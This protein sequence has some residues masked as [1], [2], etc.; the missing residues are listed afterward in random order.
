MIPNIKPSKVYPVAGQ[1]GPI[2][3]A[4]AGNA[5]TSWVQVPAGSK[6]AIAELLNGVLGGGSEQ[7]D[8]EQAT[9]SG[10]AGAKA[11]V[12]NAVT[13]AVNNTASQVEANLDQVLDVAGGFNYV[14]AKVTN[15]G[16]TGALVSIALKFGPNAY[17]D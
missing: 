13:N 14:R 4:A 3:V 9:S 16:G 12:T 1:A 10:G 8:L 6:W 11:L 15:T 17:A 2:S 7:V 5:A